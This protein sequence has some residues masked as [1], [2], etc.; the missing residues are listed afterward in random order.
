MGQESKW[1]PSINRKDPT[2]SSKASL[3]STSEDSNSRKEIYMSSRLTR[4][5]QSRWAEGINARSESPTSPSPGPTPRSSTSMTSS[6]WLTS[7]PNLAPWSNLERNSNSTISWNCS[8]A[9]PASTSSS[10]ASNWPK[11][12]S[13]RRNW[14]AGQ[15]SIRGLSS[16][17]AVSFQ[18]RIRNI[19]SLN[20]IVVIWS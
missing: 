15:F 2:S 3:K 1:S 10:R 8:T 5:H 6:T 11:R 12:I 7:S 4:R 9:A 19:D 18:T 16:K 14:P 20:K 13:C 17:N